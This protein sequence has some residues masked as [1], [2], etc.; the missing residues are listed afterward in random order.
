MVVV[1]RRI[2]A[3]MMVDRQFLIQN[4]RYDAAE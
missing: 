1:A 2:V 4:A 3:M